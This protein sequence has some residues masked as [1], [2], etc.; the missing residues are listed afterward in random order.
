VLAFVAG[1]HRYV[2][3]LF[4][5]PDRIVPEKMSKYVLLV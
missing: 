1:E 2:L 5:Q 3:V 4:K